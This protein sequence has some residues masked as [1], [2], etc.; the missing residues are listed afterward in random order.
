MDTYASAEHI[1]RTLYDTVN[2]GAKLVEMANGIAIQHWHNDLKD[3]PLEYAIQVSNMSNS[4]ILEWAIG[5]KYRNAKAAAAA[6]AAAV[7]RPPVV[8][9]R[10]LR[11]SSMLLNVPPTPPPTP[12]TPPMDIPKLEAE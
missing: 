3:N 12:P 9:T 7:E 5:V 6:T 2:G 10:M 11:S 4:L 8:R 1:H